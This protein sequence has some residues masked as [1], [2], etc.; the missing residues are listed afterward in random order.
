MFVEAVVFLSAIVGVLLALSAFVFHMITRKPEEEPEK[1]E[2]AVDDA[3]DAALEEI[4][5]TSRLIL[6]ELNE[7]YNALLFVYQLM[8]DKKKEIDDEDPPVSADAEPEL[9]T[10][11]LDISIGDELEHFPLEG[12][13]DTD[14]IEYTN[15]FVYNDTD[16]ILNDNNDN[17][18][19]HF[20]EHLIKDEQIEMKLVVPEDIN[21]IMAEAIPE[22]ASPVETYKPI[23]HP[24]FD[25]IKELQGKGLTLPEIAR[26]LGMGQGE[27]DLI[28]GL[29][30]R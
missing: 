7:K 28:I 10:T 1:V 16:E 26:Q 25:E 27:V 29:S 21:T 11:E 18:E 6:D 13:T 14:Y 17:I 3:A 23:V 5:K 24:R 12:L 30:G 9:I 19:E 4:T 20:E 15:D 2:Q 8:D 22:I